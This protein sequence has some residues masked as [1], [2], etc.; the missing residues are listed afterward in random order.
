MDR[1]HLENYIKYFLEGKLSKEKEKELLLWLKQS[2]DNRR[3]FIEIQN[4]HSRNLVRSKKTHL[5]QSWNKVHNRI[6]VSKPKLNTRQLF[7]R[8]ASVAA[9][10]VIGIISTIALYNVIPNFNRSISQQHISVPYGAKTS[11]TLPDSSVVWLNSGSSLSYS[12]EFKG[13]RLVSLIGEAYFDVKKS[14]K[15]FVVS[16]RLGEVVVKGTSFNVQAYENELLQAT[17]V[18]G[19]VLVREIVN[20]KEVILSP[21]EQVQIQNGQLTVK[22][23]ETDLYTSWKE[24]KLIFRKE[25][26]P[27]VVKR[28]ERWYNVKIDLDDDERLNDIWFTGK[29]EL[30]S[31]SEVLDLLRVTSSVDY[32]FDDKTRVIK[33]S[34]KQKK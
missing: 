28:L 19:S 10:F 15:P 25:Y 6:S 8:A 12:P 22:S 33:I 5:R 3:L 31:F 7:I 26:L 29:L 30:E 24:G 18:K 9:A 27:E 1:S 23:V 34:Y 20:K 4:K 21:G 32:T 14:K 17:L 13:K 11:I 16:T 2:N